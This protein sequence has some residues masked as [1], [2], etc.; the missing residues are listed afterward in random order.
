MT[1][2]Y[3]YHSQI[4]KSYPKYKMNAEKFLILKVLKFILLIVTSIFQHKKH[5]FRIN[6]VHK[7]R[8]HERNF[9]KL[10]TSKVIYRL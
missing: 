6:D 8:F 7:L 3:P 10:E 5:L 2:H 9:L 4:N 1:Y